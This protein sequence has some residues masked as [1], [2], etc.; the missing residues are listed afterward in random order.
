MKNSDDAANAL[1]GLAQSCNVEISCICGKHTMNVQDIIPTS[2]RTMDSEMKY[3]CAKIIGDLLPLSEEPVLKSW[4]YWKLIENRFPYDMIFKKHHM[5]IPK[6]EVSHRVHLT[7]SEDLELKRIINEFDDSDEYDAVMDN[8]RGRRSILSLY[9]VHLV[10]W[11]EKRSDF[12][13]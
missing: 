4:K 7:I 2:G 3:Q 11:H 1:A 5:L 13:Q 6:R 8:F 9:H 12:K 10:S